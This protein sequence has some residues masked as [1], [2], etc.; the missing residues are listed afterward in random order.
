MPV[1]VVPRVAATLLVLLLF[2]RPVPGLAQQP[3]IAE[4]AELDILKE[5]ARDSLRAF[6]KSLNARRVVLKEWLDALACDGS[7]VNCSSG[8]PTEM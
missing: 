8:E 2:L 4:L 3:P 7:R 1:L 6:L 5:E